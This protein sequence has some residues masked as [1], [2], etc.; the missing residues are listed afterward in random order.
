MPKLR[1]K[2]SQPLVETRAKAEDIMNFMLYWVKTVNADVK[3]KWPKLWQYQPMTAMQACM[4][5]WISQQAL[6]YYLREYPEIKDKYEDIRVAKREKIKSQAEDNL[7]RA[8]AW[9]MEIDD[10]DLAR[11]SMQYLEKTD[12]SYNIKQ[13]IDVNVKAL[14][15]NLSEEDIL[16]KIQELMAK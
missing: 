15:M 13:E 8:I 16:T 7:D 9:A 11:L 5:V 12:K 3:K 2:K 4:Q 14:H 1:A 6:H 10:V